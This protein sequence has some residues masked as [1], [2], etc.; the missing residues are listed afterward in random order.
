MN[1][2]RS[3]CPIPISDKPSKTLGLSVYYVKPSKT[4]GLSVYYVKVIKSNR[5]YLIILNYT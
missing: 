1:R 4:L 3:I 5:I 2:N